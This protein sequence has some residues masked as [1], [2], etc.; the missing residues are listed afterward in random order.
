MEIL[1][2]V[3]PSLLVFLTAWL[4]LRAFLNKESDVIQS[5]LVRDT[6]NRRIELLQNTSKTILPMRLQ[7]YERMALFCSRIEMGQ[8]VTNTVATTEMSAEMYKTALIMQ[9]DEE[10]HHNITQQV[11]MTDDLWNI[12]LLSKK[13]VTRICEKIYNDVEAAHQ[14]QNLQG[15]ASATA[16]LEAL[17]KYMQNTPQI[18][19]IHAL[20]AIKKE[21]GILFG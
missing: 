1:K 7:A 19:Y 17:V 9:V 13:E 10:F 3:L 4:V 16:F 2:L 14:D 20:T 18:G 5:I 8:L 12:I 11:Y 15:Q 21:V 6:E